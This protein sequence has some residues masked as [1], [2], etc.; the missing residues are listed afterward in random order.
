MRHRLSFESL[1]DRCL[2]AVGPLTLEPLISGFSNPVAATHAGDGSGR[3]F[4][5]EQGGLVHIVRD[6]ERV[7]RPF[8][9]VRSQLVLGGA[10]GERGLLGLAFH[11]DYASVGAPGEGKLYVYYSAPS[12]VGD[13]DSVVAEYRVSTDDPDVADFLSPDERYCDSTNHSR[14][15]T[16]VI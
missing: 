10:S 9:D 1:E 16:A 14:T 5:V 2:L 12:L 13:H 4:V 8:L 6:G 15:T 7:A 11:P 3:L